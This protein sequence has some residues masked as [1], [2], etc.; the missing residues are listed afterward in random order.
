MEEQLQYQVFPARQ[1]AVI[2]KVLTLLFL[3]TIFYLGVLVNI[4]LLSLESQPE[5]IVRWTAL[6]II[7]LIVAVGIILAQKHATSPYNFYQTY[8]QINNKMVTYSTIL[9]ITTKQDV[10]DK[11]FKTYSV[12]LGQKNFLRHI[13][14]E[15]QL[16]PYI[17]Q[18]VAY[19]H[20]L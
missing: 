19:A 5:T 17:K 18:L 10:F 4:S 20:R 2:P 13:P 15:I 6:A 16:Q 14:Q 3:G 12:N 8:L 9:T 7:L 1:R 11:M